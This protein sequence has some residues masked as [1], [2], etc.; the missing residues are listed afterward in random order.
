[1]REL[2][3]QEF[4][5]MRREVDHQQPPARPQHARRL[6]DGAAAVVE[7]VQHLMQDDDVEGIVGERQVVDVALAH[8]A[9]LQARALQPVARQQ[10]HVERQIEA[11]PALD[12][13]AEQFE[14][15]AGAGAEIQ[16]R[17]ERLVGERGADRVLHRLIGD[18]QLAD[19]VPLGGMRAEIGLRGGGARR[20]HRGEPLAVA[21]DGRV[22]RI[23][24]VEQRAG[25]LGAAA[26]LGQPEEG[27]GALAEALDQPG[28]GQKLADGAKCAAA[29][30]AGCR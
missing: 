24:P 2:L 20:P 28:L 1:M 5:L 17:A 3:A 7:E 4:L 18:M 10:Q 22:G 16:E 26:M 14:H 9:M 13:G 6:A 23:E 12:L 19:A 11:E 8:A 27:P 30:G 25:D 21:R 15:A 29:T